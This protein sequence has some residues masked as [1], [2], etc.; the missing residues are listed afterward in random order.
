MYEERKCTA[1]YISERHPTVS[2]VVADGN[3]TENLQKDSLQEMWGRG[4]AGKRKAA[5]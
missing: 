5:A 1:F 2:E 3:G 4:T